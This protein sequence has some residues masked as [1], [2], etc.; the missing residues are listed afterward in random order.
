MVENWQRHVKVGLI[1]NQKFYEAMTING[2][3]LGK[4][5]CHRMTLPLGKGAS[6]GLYVKIK[7]RFWHLA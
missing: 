2:K 6:S 3:R 4:P 5:L 1:L 7:N